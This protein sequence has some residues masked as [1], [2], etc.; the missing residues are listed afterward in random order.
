MK[1][2]LLILGLACLMLSLFLIQP[3]NAAIFKWTKVGNLRA[4][5]SDDT[6][7][8]QISGSR[9]CYYYYDNFSYYGIYNGGWYFAS[10]N[11]TAEDGTV[12]PVRAVGPATDGVNPDHIFAVPDHEEITI[13]QYRR[14]TPPTIIVD[15]NYVNDP[16]PLTGD[17]VNPD[18]ITGTADVMIESWTNTTMGVTIHQKVYAWGQ[19]NHDD[20]VIYDLTFINTGN[21]DLDDE[22]E[23]PNQTLED[24]YLMFAYNLIGANWSGPWY[25]TYGERV[26]DSTR[27]MYAYP[28]RTSGATYDN[29]GNVDL[30]TGFIDTPVH[31]GHAFLHVDKSVSD[32][33]DDWAQPHMTGVQTAELRWVKYGPEQATPLELDNLYKVMKE[34]LDWYDG[35]GYQT[36]NVLADYH[37]PRMDELGLKF[38]DDATWWNWLALTLQSVGPYTLAP[39]DSFRV[40]TALVYGS[41]DRQTGWDVGNAWLNGSATWDGDDNLPQPYVDYPDLMDNDNDEAKDQWVFS[42]RDSL[43]R[44]VWAA[45][46]AV[47]N[48][49]EVPVPPP[50]PSVEVLGQA[51]KIVVSWGEESETVSDFAGYRVYRAILTPDTTYT[52]IFECGEGTGNELTHVY[53]DTTAA[54]GLAYYYY[55][56]A[57]DNGTD[58]GVDAFGKKESLESGRYLNMTTRATHLARPPGNKLDDIVIVP[59]P[60]NLSA[61]YNQFGAESE[62]DKLMFYNIPAVCTIKIFTE[63]GDLVRTI[64]HDDGSG[65]EP[66]RVPTEQEVYMTSETGQILVSGLYIAYFETPDGKST[67]KKFIIIR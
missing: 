47:Q 8:D 18:K 40:V 51:D 5:I 4:K 6:D 50:A 11:W 10:K 12:W 2:T 30:S 53:N 42:G 15:N 23:L 65:D 34:G 27:M 37:S 41:I 48:N 20:Y 36:T 24:A 39:N 66:F 22:I 26:G 13:R 32:H 59:N 52:K 33:T 9:H 35:S 61:K 58:N 57:F 17:E 56:T 44:N 28:N 46:W 19:K 62:Q 21:T 38:P 43:F 55:V 45:Q 67:Y 14:D 64:E 31:I 1:K 54:R 3:T 16:F 7:Q 49:Y 60:F 25:S 63:S 29:T